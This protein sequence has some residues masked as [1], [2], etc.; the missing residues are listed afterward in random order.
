MSQTSDNSRTFRVLNLTDEVKT[1]LT[2]VNAV[3]SQ[4]ESVNYVEVKDVASI[5]GVRTVLDEN[6]MKYKQCSYSTFVRFK[7]ELTVEQLTKL[8]NDLCANVNVL[9]VRV[10]ENNHTGKL[11]VDKLED[12]N[13][14]K[15]NT[16]D[17]SFYRFS[18]LNVPRVQNRN[19]NGAGAGRN[20]GEWQQVPARNT[21]S[22]RGRYAGA[23]VGNSAPRDGAPRDGGAPRGDGA[24][25]GAGR[26]GGRG[27]GRGGASRGFGRGGN[28]NVASSSS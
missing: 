8:V 15:G 11:V 25:R 19:Y 2:A 24:P 10:D 7:D 26:G 6:E 28:S 20:D 3:V 4:H 9:Y 13:T 22:V 1:K 27:T 17:V 21:N 5:A 14:L 23:V 18:P 16:G 12:Y